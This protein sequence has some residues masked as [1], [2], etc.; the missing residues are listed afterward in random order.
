MYFFI[1][2]GKI[3]TFEAECL[4]DALSKCP[5]IDSLALNRE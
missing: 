2:D 5:K 3:G 4:A 1:P